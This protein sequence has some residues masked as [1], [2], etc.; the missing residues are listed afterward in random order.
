MNSYQQEQ[1]D[2][3]NLVTRFLSELDDERIQLLNQK[4]S[5]YLHFRKSVDDFLTKHFSRTCTQTCYQNQRSACCSKDGIIT[6]FGDVLINAL[7]STSSELQRLAQ[8]VEAPRQQMK[9][10]FLESVGCLWRIKPAVCVMF[11]C[12]SA[13]EEVFSRNPQ[14]KK[15]WEELK[16]LERT[17]KWPDQP[18]LFDWLEQFALTFGYQSPLMY[19]HNSPGLM[20]VKKKAGLI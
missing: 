10:I 6:F 4:I 3:L 5:P 7:C 15:R 2:A 12:P 11:I 20:R 8:A 17:F 13:L 14:A 16:A 19:M 1:I 9:C 18:V